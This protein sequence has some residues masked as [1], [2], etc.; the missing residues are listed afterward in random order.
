MI[1]TNRQRWPPRP[2]RTAG[3]HTRRRD[4]RV[5]AATVDSPN[6]TIFPMPS[7]PADGGRD[8][9]KSSGLDRRRATPARDRYRREMPVGEHDSGTVAG[10]AIEPVEQGVR[11]VGD[12]FAGLCRGLTFVGA[13]VPSDRRSRRRPHSGRTSSAVSRARASGLES[14]RSICHPARVRAASPAFWRPRS[15]N[16]MRSAPCACLPVTART[17]RDGR[18]GRDGSRADVNPAGPEPYRPERSSDAR[19]R[20]VAPLGAVGL[21]S[22]TGCTIW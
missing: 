21:G 15:V 22:V 12:V 18:A 19:S 1:C 17:G 8:E 2:G 20:S 6:D 9:R 3:S 4:D 10:R 16:G 5:A 11:P 7:E 13:A 14:A